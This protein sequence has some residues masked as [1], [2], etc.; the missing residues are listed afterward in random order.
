MSKCPKAVIFDLDGTLVHSSI[1]FPRMKREVI[2][3]FEEFG[4][5]RNLLSVDKTISSNMESAREY[6]LQMGQ[7]KA[8]LRIE[9]EIERGLS[10]IE[11][12][13]LAD[14]EEVR[15]ATSTLAWIMEKGLA[16]GVLTRG[17]R[18]YASEVLVKTSL[19][20]M[21][22]YMVCRDDF[23]WWEAKPNGLALRR[24]V[25]KLGVE[26]KE[27]LLVGDHC[28][29]L[30]CARST[31]MEFIGVLTGSFDEDGWIDEGLQNILDSIALLP[32]YINKICG[33]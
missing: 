9:E 7:E 24:L 15:Y 27:T 31:G 30:E 23:P 18:R 16:I 6:L 22:R 1:D 29:D 8:L 13:A 12:E 28:M 19:D 10:N 11:M 20:S 25:E 21:I 17:S 32:D 33:P 5:P 2:R 14:V 26:P 3:Q 4:V